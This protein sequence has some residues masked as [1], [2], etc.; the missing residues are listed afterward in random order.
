[1]SNCHRRHAAWIAG[2][3]VFL[4]GLQEASGHGVMV[5]PPSRNSRGLQLLSPVCPGGACQWYSQ[6]CSIG[7]KEASQVPSVAGQQDC[8][9]PAEPRLTWDKHEDLLQFKND[10]HGKETT[11]FP[12]RYPGSAPV[13]DA[14]G[15]AGGGVAPTFG[16]K[17]PPPGTAEGERGSALPPLLGKTTWIAGGTAKVGWGIAAN[18]GGGYQYRLC[19]AKEELTEA[20]FQK[21][22]LSFVGSKQWLRF[23]DGSTYEIPAKRVGGDLVMPAG[24]EWTRNPIPGCKDDGARD[25]LPCQGPAFEPPPLQDKTFSYGGGGQPGVYGYSGGHCFGNKEKDPAVECT[26]EEYREANF[27]F[28]IVDEIQVPEGLEPGDYVIGFRWDCEQTNQ[29]WSSCGDVKITK[30]GEG[31][32]TA[33]FEDVE[34]CD[35][36]CGVSSWCGHCQECQEDKESE[37]CKDCWEPKLWWGGKETWMPRAASIQCLGGVTSWKPGDDIHAAW[38]PNCQN[39]WSTQGSCEAR[40]RKVLQ[41]ATAGSG[42]LPHVQV[43]ACSMLFTVLLALAL[44]A[45]TRYGRNNNGGGGRTIVAPTVDAETGPQK[46]QS[47]T[48]LS[49]FAA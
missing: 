21:T 3:L 45:R 48:E 44:W 30:A 15:A 16:Q 19:P 22:P 37:K 23:S 24:H 49:A 10:G 31:Q 4:G 46:A 25:K 2:S 33:P 34:G 47:S 14:C 1:M 36:C 5:E 35:V 11:Y 17:D 12:W 7:C 26:G 28:N 42:W 27:D 20:C 41:A 43:L 13:V 8:P 6:G 29:I 18:H 38:S 40:D 9:E 32:Q 39:C